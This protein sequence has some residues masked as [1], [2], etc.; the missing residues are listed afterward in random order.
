MWRTVESGKHRQIVC[1]GKHNACGRPVYFVREDRVRERCAREH[2][3]WDRRDAAAM[4]A[5]HRQE[6]RREHERRD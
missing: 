1:C 6:E 2:P 3:G 5:E 4:H